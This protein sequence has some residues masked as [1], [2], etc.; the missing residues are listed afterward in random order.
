VVDTDLF[1]NHMLYQSPARLTES[2][3]PLRK[4]MSSLFCYTTVFNAIEL[5]SLAQS[6]VEVRAIEDTLQAVKILGLN[7]RSAKSVGL[8]I[9]EIRT[10]R[11]RDFDKLIASVCVESRLPL[12]TGRAQ[13]YRGIPNLT[14][15]SA[16]KVVR[17][18]SASELESLFISARKERT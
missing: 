16:E 11:V 12:V 1:I 5:F 3:S 8:G 14:V 18:R 4:I 13:R 9:G 7:G 6:E 17:S 2:I 15:V 10:K